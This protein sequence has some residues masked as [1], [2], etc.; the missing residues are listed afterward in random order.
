MKRTKKL[1]PEHRQAQLA[2]CRRD[3]LRPLFP[4]IPPN[5]PEHEDAEGKYVMTMKQKKG[6]SPSHSAASTNFTERSA[7]AIF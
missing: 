6:E 2:I 4:F 3:L 1:N 7:N 5:S